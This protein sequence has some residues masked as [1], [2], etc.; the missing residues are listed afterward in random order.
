MN[1]TAGTWYIWV[2]GDYAGKVFGSIYDMR[3]QVLLAETVRANIA[4]VVVCSLC[5]CLKSGRALSARS[6]LTCNARL[7]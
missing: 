1:V 5:Q 4:P 6:G 2:K 3:T 7:S